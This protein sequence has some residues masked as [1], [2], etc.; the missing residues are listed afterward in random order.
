M[1]VR[2]VLAGEVRENADRLLQRGEHKLISRL[3]SGQ[4]AALF[5]SK[6]W[7]ALGACHRAQKG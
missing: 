4:E 6:I 7:P 5:A 2:N 3:G 1:S